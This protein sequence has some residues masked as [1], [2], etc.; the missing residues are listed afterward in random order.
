M[1][2]NV[3]GQFPWFQGENEMSEHD[4]EKWLGIIGH[5]IPHSQRRPKKLVRHDQANCDVPFADESLPMDN[6]DKVVAIGIAFAVVV[7]LSLDIIWMLGGL[8]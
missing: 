6:L 7:M 1:S 8:K 2:Y 5:G 4:E 3:T